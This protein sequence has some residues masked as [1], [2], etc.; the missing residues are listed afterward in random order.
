MHSAGR[1]VI[2]ILVIACIAF[3]SF[4]DLLVPSEP[5]GSLSGSTLMDSTLLISNIGVLVN[6]PSDDPQMTQIKHVLRSCIEC[7]SWKANEDAWYMKRDRRITALLNLKS[8]LDDN[9]R[10][11]T[12]PEYPCESGEVGIGGPGDGRKITCLHHPDIGPEGIHQPNL[13]PGGCLLISIGSNADF[14]YEIQMHQNLPNCDIHTYDPTVFEDRLP[15]ERK[16]EILKNFRTTF[17]LEGLGDKVSLWTADGVQAQ[18][19]VVTKPL[20]VM[21]EELNRKHISIL[22]VDCEGCEFQAFFDDIFPAMKAGKLEINQL[23]IELH[24]V[25][26]E[27]I[28]L[29]SDFMLAADAA[30]LRLFSY[31]YNP[32]SVKTHWWAAEFSFISVKKP[33]GCDVCIDMSCSSTG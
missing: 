18:T 32:L 14:T 22:K 24:A 27:E 2:A 28:N 30:G 8:V 9:F 16:Q 20:T 6:L 3:F 10:L 4:H 13:K 33:V 17:H 7:H 23:L 29:I 26:F 5:Y 12:S 11:P 1:T 25:K 19:D 15:T 21:M 31:E